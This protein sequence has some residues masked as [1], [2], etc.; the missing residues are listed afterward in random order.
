[1]AEAGPSDQ[2]GWPPPDPHLASRHQ[3]PLGLTEVQESAPQ[4]A[5]SQQ[6]VVSCKT[7]ESVLAPPP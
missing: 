6:E 5:A 2:H 1:M 4:R 7:E 3:A